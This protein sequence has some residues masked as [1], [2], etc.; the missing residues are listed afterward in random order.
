MPEALARKYAT[1]ED[2][3]ERLAVNPRTI[4]RMIARGE[5]TGYRLGNKLVRVNPAEIDAVM[6]PIPTVNG[7]A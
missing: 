7:A 5:I 3:A 4:R 1:I 2:E 6:R